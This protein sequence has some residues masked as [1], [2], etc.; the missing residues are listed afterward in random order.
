MGRSFEQAG[1]RYI[2]W[3]APLFAVAVVM[4][5]SA[6]L[7]AATARTPPQTL[8]VTTRL[9]VVNVVAHNKKGEPVEGLTQRD[10]TL[11]DNG[12]PQ[13]I[14]VFSVARSKAKHASANPLPPN[15]FS[16]RVAREGVVPVNV[17]VILLNGWGGH[18]GTSI[19]V[20]N[21]IIKFFQQN[22]PSGRMALYAVGGP[23]GLRVIQDFTG[24]PSSLL[25]AIRDF[26]AYPGE[27]PSA[28]GSSADVSVPPLSGRRNA[29]TRLETA[30]KDRSASLEAI[31]RDRTVYEVIKDIAQ[32][33]SGLPGR[34]SLIWVT[35]SVPSVGPGTFSN[36]QGVLGY[37][38]NLSEQARKFRDAIRA[39]NQ[40]DVAVYPVDAHGLVVGPAK[41][42]A[43]HGPDLT[44]LWGGETW[45]IAMD[46]WAKQTGGR[47]FYYTNGLHQAIGKAL[48]DSKFTYTLGYYPND[49]AWNGEYRNIK[50]LVDRKDVQLRYRRGYFAT[51][52]SV[53]TQT[54][55]VMLLQ[56]AAARPL[57]SSGLGVT[58]DISPAGSSTSR[59][60]KAAVYVDGHGLTFRPDKGRYDVSFVVWAGQYTK[61]GA[62]L[63]ENSKKVSFK[64]N[65]A[66][67]HFALAGGLGLNLLE[68]ANPGASELRIGV[69][70]NVSGTIGTVRIP[71]AKVMKPSP[72]RHAG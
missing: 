45:T 42:G 4:C 15:A 11:L 32:H 31:Y 34:K 60:F 39:L 17:V 46:D 35:D 71:L 20:R 41:I 49:V 28:K 5:G 26:R 29:G 40:A 66:N 56:I 64:L 33:L 68:K 8:R 2:L 38:G 22:P 25:K 13:Q 27:E 65:N 10:F 69:L 58:V 14:S 44:P 61:Q 67:Y 43:V 55:P 51:S 16:N 59:N 30:T 54:S 72:M 23:T 63:E 70:D 53:D 52:E 62:L 48:D 50:V 19:F 21:E 47:A 7:G 6:W 24:D 1:R 36:L 37:E 57:D 9:V 18:S 3:P 12:K